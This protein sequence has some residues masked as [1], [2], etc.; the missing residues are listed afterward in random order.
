[1]VLT[2]LILRV[3]NRTKF[4]KMKK[5]LL[6]IPTLLLLLVGCKDASNKAATSALEKSIEAVSGKKIDMAD[7][8]NVE[9]NKSE[10]NLVL[11]G[12]S[13]DK[14]FENAFG[15]ITASKE[16]IAITITG[17][18]NGQDNILIGFTGKDLIGERPIKGKMV[19][20]EN[21]GFTFSIMKVADNGMDAQ[22]SYEAE[23]EIV[24][25]QKDKIV[26]RVKGKIG[27]S[28]DSEKPENWKPFEGTVTLNYPVFQALDSSKEDFLY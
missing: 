20:G 19:K 26:I 9:K 14:N 11:D 22:L 23:G 18:E 16:T 21:D 4:K 2:L 25:L 5:I 10:V 27:S 8:D 13:I 7:V 17:G 3:T 24:S 28:L 1:M 12:E 6:T 15:S